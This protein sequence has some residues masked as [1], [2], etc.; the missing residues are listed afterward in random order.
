MHYIFFPVVLIQ[1]DMMTQGD[2]L[3]DIVDRR[4]HAP[5]EAFL[6]RGGASDE[7]E[8]LT[9]F[10]RMTV[11]RNFR[12]QTGYGDHKVLLALQTFRVLLSIS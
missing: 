1:V 9:F 10:C 3:F 11:S 2:T 5:V 4:D 8:E 6:L 7:Q 12:R